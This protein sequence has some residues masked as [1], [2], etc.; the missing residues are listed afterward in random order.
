MMTRAGIASPSTGV[1]DHSWLCASATPIAPSSGPRQVRGSFRFSGEVAFPTNRFF[2]CGA[3]Y[4]RVMAD[5]LEGTSEFNRH[6]ALVTG[7]I[8]ITVSDDERLD[9]FHRRPPTLS[10]ELA[11]EAPCEGCR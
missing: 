8:P 5:I 6:H 9:M 4:V 2:A 11:G 7:E 10:M 1:Y 3:M